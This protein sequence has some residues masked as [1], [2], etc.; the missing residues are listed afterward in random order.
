MKNVKIKIVK[1]KFGSSLSERIF[2]DSL[3][4]IADV[5]N[6][7]LG[8][9][10]GDEKNKPVI[11]I[12][13]QFKIET[14]TPGITKIVDFKFKFQDLITFIEFDGIKWHMLLKARKKDAAVDRTIKKLNLRLIRIFQKAFIK[15][16]DRSLALIFLLGMIPNQNGVISIKTE[17]DLKKWEKFVKENSKEI[18]KILSCIFVKMIDKVAE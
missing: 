11:R 8:L 7:V 5:L 9:F 2:R 18:Q 16:R 1:V 15:H 4:A 6:T 12:N 14:D 13:Q 17:Q 3:E 10:C